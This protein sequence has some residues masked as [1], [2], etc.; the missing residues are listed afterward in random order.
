MLAACDVSKDDAPLPVDDPGIPGDGGNNNN[1]NLVVLSGSIS[2]APGS[3]VDSDV[4]DPN[5]PYQSND[6]IA[7]AQTIG[8]PTTLGG[9]VNLPGFGGAGRSFEPGDSND[10]YIAQLFANQSVTIT[11]ADFNPAANRVAL[12]LLNENGEVVLHTDSN[13][14]TDS[15]G[16]NADGIYY[17][18]VSALAGAS[19]YVLTLGLSGQQ[20]SVADAALTVDQAFVPGEVIVE[21]KPDSG[22]SNRQITAYASPAAVAQS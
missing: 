6:T 16:V 21:Y 13:S 11:V 9:Y 2:I 20:Q 4:N 14:Q 17:L 5:A 7:Q 15:I 1:T 12:F 22:A 10:F 3:A 18:Q 19:S 8:N